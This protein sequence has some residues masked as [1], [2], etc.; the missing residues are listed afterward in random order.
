[1]LRSIVHGLKRF[2]CVRWG[3]SASVKTRCVNNFSPNFLQFQRVQC[4]STDYTD[5]V[6]IDFSKRDYNDDD[7]STEVDMNTI[8]PNLETNPEFVYLEGIQERHYW[9]RIR[10]LMKN[11]GYKGYLEDLRHGRGKGI[12][13]RNDLAD[14]V[15]PYNGAL[16]KSRRP[17]PF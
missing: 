11:L 9:G 2:Q 14:L 4:C 5:Y 7:V 8:S 13:I 6:V 15:K 10:S 1:M 16:Y 12:F 17:N 3:D